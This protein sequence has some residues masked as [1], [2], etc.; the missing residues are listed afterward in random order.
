MKIQVDVWL[1]GTDFATTQTIDEIVREPQAWE[2]E[3][4]RALIEGMLRVMH[5][6]KTKAPPE[7]PIALRGISWIVN[8]YEDSGVVVALEITMGAAVA[9]PFNIE[10]AALD[11]MINRVLARPAAPSSTIH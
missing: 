10:K 3:D 11:A 6:Q 4:V 5:T 2:D 8:P 1:R 9:G 7:Q